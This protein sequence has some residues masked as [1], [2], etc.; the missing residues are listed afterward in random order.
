MVGLSIAVQLARSGH[1]VTVISGDRAG[2]ASVASGAMLGCLTEVTRYTRTTQHG[3]LKLE[4]GLAAKTLWSEWL[5]SING[6]VVTA[7]GFVISNASGG[8]AEDANFEAVG[9]EPVSPS[10][11]LGL[12]PVPDKRPL[13]AAYFQGEG[14]LDARKLLKA[15]L[16]AAEVSG[17]RI[18]NAEMTNVEMNLGRL[19]G[20][21][22]G[23]GEWVW[24]DCFVSALGAFTTDLVSQLPEPHRLLPSLSGEGVA[25]V[26]RRSQGQPFLFPVRTPGRAGGCGLHL[27][28]LGEGIE[29]VGATNTPSSATSAVANLGRTNFLLQCAMDQLDRNLYSSELQ[30]V[31]VGNRPMT[32]DTFPAIGWSHIEG[33]YMVYG[34]YRD[35]LQQSPEIAR[36]VAEDISTGETAQ[37]EFSPLRPPVPFGSVGDSIREYAVESV[38][39]AFEN[40]LQLPRYMPTARLEESFAASASKFYDEAEVEYPFHPDVLPV[41]VRSRD[42]RLLDYLRML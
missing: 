15:L 13:R 3:L 27:V 35:G 24:G 41:M 20:V 16:V 19:S 7:G 37:M 39:S 32:I 38:A 30:Q 8:S 14:S 22:L 25:A 2:A 5:D 29:Y 6:P 40:D 36:R 33:L 18:V 9:G 34:T 4:I 21:R 28:P 26:T 23:T 31:L 17:V 11:I 10:E 1:P 12:N 42:R